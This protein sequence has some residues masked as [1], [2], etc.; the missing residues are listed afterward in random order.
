MPMQILLSLSFALNLF[1]AQVTLAE[2]IAGRSFD[3]GRGFAFQIFHPINDGI[4]FF[5]LLKPSRE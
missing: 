4:Y 5:C 2:R 3:F 1:D